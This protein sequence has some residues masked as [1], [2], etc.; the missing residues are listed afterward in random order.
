M[1]S[2][3]IYAFNKIKY[4]NRQKKIDTLQLLNLFTYFGE[5]GHI[6]EQIE[7]KKDHISFIFCALINISIKNINNS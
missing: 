4:K 6:I 7:Y 1:L 2:E 3:I 5:Y